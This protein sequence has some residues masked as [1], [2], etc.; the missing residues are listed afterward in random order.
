VRINDICEQVWVSN[1]R[2]YT[3]TDYDEFSHEQMIYSII[4]VALNN[5]VLFILIRK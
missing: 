5:F 4:V 2:E 3:N 1:S